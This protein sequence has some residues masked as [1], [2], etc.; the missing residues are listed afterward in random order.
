MS[1]YDT[2]SDQSVMTGYFDGR[3][4][5]AKLDDGVT[6][7]VGVAEPSLMMGYY[8]GRDD[9]AKLDDGVTMMVGVA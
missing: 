1:I 4:G 6:M 2:L 7:M 3:S 8:D 9:R 5:R